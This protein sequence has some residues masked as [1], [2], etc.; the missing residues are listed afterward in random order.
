MMKTTYKTRRGNGKLNNTSSMEAT[1]AR[2]MKE[3]DPA[4]D[5]HGSD[6]KVLQIACQDF[7]NYAKFAWKSDNEELDNHEVS[8]KIAKFIEQNRADAESFIAVWTGLWLGKWKQ[9]V[10]LVL[11]NQTPKLPGSTPK[12]NAGTPVVAEELEN[13]QEIID[14]I[15]STL[16]RNAEICGTA[17]VAENILKLELSK[18]RNPLLNDT[19]RIFAILN[20]ALC[21]ARE[22]AR[23][24]S[25]MIF[26]KIDR[27]YFAA[28]T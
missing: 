2:E 17:I 5:V 24:F 3:A 23:N 27:G 22:L 7:V 6:R 14:M 26:V 25:P 15:V 18:N 19:E 28:A 8:D 16:I 20:G 11:C 21:R 12:A 9:R 1:I 4:L 10:K 13:E